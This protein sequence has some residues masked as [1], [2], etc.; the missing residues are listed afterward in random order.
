[1]QFCGECLG[2]DALEWWQWVAPAVVGAENGDDA[3]DRRV[4]ERLR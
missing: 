1:M 3:G 2:E 4:A